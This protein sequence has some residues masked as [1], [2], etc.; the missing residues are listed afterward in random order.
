[1]QFV[2][3]QSATPIYI[4][5]SCIFTMYVHISESRVFTLKIQSYKLFGWFLRF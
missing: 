3:I 5:F 4:Q 2:L 1:M